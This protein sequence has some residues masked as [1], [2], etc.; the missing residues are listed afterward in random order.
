MGNKTNCIGKC[1]LKGRV[2]SGCNRTIDEI[3]IWSK[4]SPE[5]RDDIL[6]QHKYMVGWNIRV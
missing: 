6:Y 5:Q 3:T 2:C 4:L 1:V